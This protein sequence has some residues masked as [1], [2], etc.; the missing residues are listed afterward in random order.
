[1]NNISNGY[2]TI[3]EGQDNMD[4]KNK[5]EMLLH[6]ESQA[7]ASNVLQEHFRTTMCDCFSRGKINGNYRI[8]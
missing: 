7:R 1:M 2:I 8:G 6:I 5:W 3:Q 4:S